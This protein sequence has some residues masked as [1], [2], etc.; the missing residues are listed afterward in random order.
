VLRQLVHLV[1]AAA[2]THFEL[3][4]VGNHEQRNQNNMDKKG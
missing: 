4:E 3:V 1:R 2:V